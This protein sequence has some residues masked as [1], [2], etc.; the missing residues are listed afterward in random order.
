MDNF[1]DKLAHKIN[2]QE[3]IKA[4]SAAEAMEMRKLQVRI[5]EY[6]RIMEDMRRVNLQNI[7]LSES[8]QKMTEEALAK[9]QE[10]QKEEDAGNELRDSVEAVLNDFKSS[11]EEALKRSDEY[12]HT[13]S[14][15]VYRNV[16]AVITDGFKEQEEKY[17]QTQAGTG[18]K[19]RGLKPLAI[20]V[21]VLAAANVV[22]QVLQIMG[23]L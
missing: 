13:E 11:V 5:E 15:K 4:N 20:V 19:L 1:M 3:M 6:E 10:F 21:L 18:K 12:V 17:A 14:V 16:Q 9:I 8:M 22:L 23:I 7:Q 2:A